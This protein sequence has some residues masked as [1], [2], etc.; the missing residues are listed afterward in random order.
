MYVHNMSARGQKMVLELELQV[1]VSCHLGAGHWT[2]VLCKSH[3][4]S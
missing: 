3:K 2:E 4:Y 1:F